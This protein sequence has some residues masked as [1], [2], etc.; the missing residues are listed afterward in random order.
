MVE[1]YTSKEEARKLR[2]ECSNDFNESDSA[3]VI[4]KCLEHLTNFIYEK[5][6]DKRKRAID[7][8]VELCEETILVSDPIEQSK[9]IKENIYYYFNAKYSREGN[10]AQTETGETVDADLKKDFDYDLPIDETIWKYIEK[11]IDFDDNGAII[12]NIKHLRGA[13]MRMLRGTSGS[14]QFNILK[15]YSLYILSPSSPKLLKE[16]IE[17]LKIG[18]QKWYE[19]EPD[20][21]NFEI[22]FIKFKS[23]IKRHLGEIPDEMFGDVE[24]DY[25]TT[26]YLTLFK[27]FNYKFLKNYSNAVTTSN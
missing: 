19:L 10:V 9:K 8:M 20:K 17:E 5:I 18:I 12:N 11:I 27:K 25:Y 16:A 26:K 14:P 22:F 23:N 6:A 1:R 7:D 2:E 24:D 15:A 21:F 13:T 3:T 4:S